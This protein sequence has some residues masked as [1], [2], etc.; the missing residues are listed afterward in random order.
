MTNQN[1]TNILMGL[2]ESLLSAEPMSPP[3]RPKQIDMAYDEI[4]RGNLMKDNKIIAK[5]RVYSEHEGYFDKKWE[6]E[7]YNR[8]SL[9]DLWDAI[10]T[11]QD[12]EMK[13]KLKNKFLQ[14]SKV[15]NET[16]KPYVSLRINWKR[17]TSEFGENFDKNM[18]NNRQQTSAIDWNN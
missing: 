16:P 8:S 9:F 17:F 1:S 7:S 10:K 2:N 4:R 3:M 18:Q 11:C 15:I 12:K 6:V 14:F 13:E 5:S